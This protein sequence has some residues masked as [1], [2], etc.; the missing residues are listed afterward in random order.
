M[1]GQHMMPDG[2]MM[3]DAAMKSIP[4]PDDGIPPRDDPDMQPANDNQASPEEQAQYNQFVGRAMELIYNQQMF[5]RIVE[6]LR[7]GGEE[8]QSA[9][10]TGANGPARGLAQATVM[11]LAKIG[12]AAEEAGQ[13]LSPDVVFHGGSE[14]F[15]QLAE[16]SDKAGIS[17]YAND[18]D[19]LEAAYF[20]TI[21]LATE[22]MAESGDIDQ[23]EAKAAMQKLVDMDAN[24]QLEQIFRDLDTKDRGDQRAD[25]EEAPEADA[26]EPA[27]AGGMMPRG[28]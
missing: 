25:E 7:G 26:A 27:M 17:D 11:V 12:S 14:I 18:R 22:Q 10:D 8:G 6:M 28:M 4:S 21:D 13:T 5:P 20:L 24:G 15:A 1:E 16:I 2:T 23:E 9:E 19:A 3:D